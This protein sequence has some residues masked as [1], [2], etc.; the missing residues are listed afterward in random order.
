MQANPPESGASSER[1]SA[2]DRMVGLLG[3]LKEQVA[4]LRRQEQLTPPELRDRQILE[5]N[6]MLN[7]LHELVESAKV[8][9][10]NWTEEDGER[11]QKEAEELA[12][13]LRRDDPLWLR[14]L[15]V[16]LQQGAAGL[17]QMRRNDPG[18]TLN[19]VQGT[20]K[21]AGGGVGGAVAGGAIGTTLGTTL[22]Y[23]TAGMIGGTVLGAVGAPL[24]IEG[25]ANQIQ[26]PKTRAVV[27]TLA[28]GS[29]AAGAAVLAP[30]AIPAILISLG[31]GG[32]INLINWL[33]TRNADAVPTE[34]E[35]REQVQTQ[36]ERGRVAPQGV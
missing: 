21:V 18:P 15:A 30:A 14:K 5:T 23:T 31:I 19:A 25:L 8:E 20:A 33:R 11:V 35:V 22:G 36:T 24:A 3:D 27:K 4:T 32:T 28:Y 13:N 6:K 1:R 10:R 29:L 2:S 16:E 17:V 7:N 34:T 26:E 12:Q 9:A